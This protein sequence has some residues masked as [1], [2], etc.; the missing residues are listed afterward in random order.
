MS[1]DCQIYSQVLSIATLSFFAS[2]QVPNGAKLRRGFKLSS[3]VLV[4]ALGA[5]Y[6]G[7]WIGAFSASW[8]NDGTN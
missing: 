1:K 5:C 3:G 8:I 4:V 2:S 6:E 7:V